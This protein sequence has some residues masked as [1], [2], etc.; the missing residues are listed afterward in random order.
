ADSQ[1]TEAPLIRSARRLPPA[2]SRPPTTAR[3]STDGISYAQSGGIPAFDARGEDSLRGAR[4]SLIGTRDRTT[5]SS[6]D[7]RTGGQCNPWAGRNGLFTL[8]RPATTR[9]QR[10]SRP[11]NDDR[12]GKLESI[13][14]IRNGDSVDYSTGNTFGYVAGDCPALYPLA[15]MYAWERLR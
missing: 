11:S 3:R 13:R 1:P 7:S 12:D 6:G 15:R 9:A 4:S 10:I 5:L 8:G 2:V 14:A